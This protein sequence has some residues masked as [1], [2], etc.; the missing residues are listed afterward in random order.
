VSSCHVKTSMSN[1]QK[2]PAEFDGF[3]DDYQALLRDP[4]R[5]KFTRDNEFFFERKL[6]VI[7]EFFDRAHL[8]TRELKWLDVGCGRGDLLR[9][10]SHRFGGVAGCDPSERMLQSCHGFDVRHQVSEERLPFDDSTFDFITAVC[11]YHHVPKPRRAALT[12]EMKRLLG[13]RGVIC[14]IEHN[15]FNPVT[16]LIVSRSPIDADAQLL[17]PAE[18]KKLLAE[19]GVEVVRSVYFLLFP[20]RL[21]RRF[22]YVERSLSATPLGGQYAV[23]ARNDVAA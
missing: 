1:R 12:L 6:E 5:E 18:A 23:F 2:P 13:P 4:L 20:Q 19:T 14:I 3:A 15:P 11:V 17:R 22:A 8:N 16:R 21:Y 10:G 9:S 7:Q